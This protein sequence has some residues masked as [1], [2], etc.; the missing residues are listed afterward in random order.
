MKTP[1]MMDLP[2]P[3]TP[4]REWATG[5]RLLLEAARGLPVIGWETSWRLSPGQTC[6]DRLL[7]GFAT[8]GVAASRLQ[9][10]A[11]SLGMP[12][13]LAQGFEQELPQARRVLLSAELGARAWDTS[14]AP[15]ARR[16]AELKAYL[17]F[18]GAADS[19]SAGLVSDAN[20]PAGLGMRGRKWR[21]DLSQPSTGAVVC[22]TSDYWRQS[23]QPR[24]I[25]SLL[26]HPSGEREAMRP[27]HALV[28]AALELALWRQPK[29]WACDFLTVTESPTGRSSFC[30][31]MHD[32]GLTVN[33]LMPAL[34]ALLHA[35]QLPSALLSRIP[36]QRRLSWLAA[37]IDGAGLPFLT[38]YG[39]ARLADA[40]LALAFGAS[41]DHD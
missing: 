37:G 10:L 7:L 1:G 34:V 16:G 38:L 9:G 26:D 8:E 4:S 14:L 5:V 20:L 24:D 32:S 13:E 15:V 25:V 18:D 29:G 23:L 3:F 35:W 22:R 27:A 30:I 6:F 17:E 11:S 33:E 19:E 40:R 2:W 31:R 39:E 28:C 21:A 41:H 36:S 12:P